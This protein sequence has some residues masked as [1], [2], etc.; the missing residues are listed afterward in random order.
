V[1]PFEIKPQT[2]DKYSKSLEPDEIEEILMGEESDEKLEETDKVMEPRVRSSSSLEDE[3]DNEEAEVMFR[4]TIAGDSSNVLDFT[5]PPNRINR[6]PT[7]N[8]NAESYSFKS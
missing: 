3:D 4:A 1:R 7:P 6:S 2:R 5:G 8:M